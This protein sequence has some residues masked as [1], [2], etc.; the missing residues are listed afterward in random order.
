MAHTIS[1]LTEEEK[2]AYREWIIP[3][4]PPKYRE[5]GLRLIYNTDLEPLKIPEYGRI[6]HLMARSLRE[7]PDKEDRNRMA[8]KIIELMGR[9]SPHLRDV[10]DFQHKLWDHLFI[11]AGLDVDIDSPYERPRQDQI[12]FRAPKPAYPQKG[13]KYRFYGDIIRK[14]IEVAAEWEEGPLKDLL[15]KTIANHM[16]KNYLNWNK[17][18]VDDEVIFQHLYELSGGKINLTGAG[19]ELL[20]RDQ[21]MRY[22][23]RAYHKN[24]R[25]NYRK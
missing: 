10:E 1:R 7:I 17:D 21:L 19:N 22:K 3:L 11:M 6:I 4:L 5:A 20:S 15:I 25:K 2:K 16:K 14:L 18:H 8:R 23:R 13:Y 12:R 24:H 9:K